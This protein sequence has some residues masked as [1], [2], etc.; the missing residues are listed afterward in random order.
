MF[1]QKDRAI[2]FL[3]IS[4]LGLFLACQEPV[5]AQAAK[6]SSQTPAPNA[7]N[8]GQRIGGVIKDA[9]STAF[10][11]VSGIG[12][13]IDAIWAKKPNSGNNVNRTQLSQ[14]AMNSQADVNKLITAQVQQK[15]TP[16]QE[17]AGELQIVSQ[18]GVPT[19]TASTEII[20]TTDLLNSGK[21]LQGDDWTE[22]RADWA[23]AKSQLELLKNVGDVSK[24]QDFWL[25][26]KL[27]K[28]QQASITAVARIDAELK[29]NSPNA[30]RLNKDFNDLNATLSDITAALGYEVS[31]MQADVKSLADWA[32]GAAGGETHALSPTEKKYVDVLNKRYR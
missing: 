17:V 20:K 1:R 11:G 16:L 10:P 30:Q 25:R 5:F 4:L 8:L 27:S 24:I 7:P 31:N 12:G 28:I 26:D 19:T 9:I 13:L 2:S 32:N 15:L 23:A 6:S 22:L 18:F 29:P 21:T 3:A 14:A